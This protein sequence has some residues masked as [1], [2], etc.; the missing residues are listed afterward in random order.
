MK[1]PLKQPSMRH[2]FRSRQRHWTTYL[3]T[4]SVLN[5][6]RQNNNGTS[7]PQRRPREDQL[8]ATNL[9]AVI[10]TT[11]PGCPLGGFVTRSI[12][13]RVRG[14][15][16]CFVDICEL[17]LD[18]VLVSVFLW[19]RKHSLHRQALMYYERVVVSFRMPKKPFKIAF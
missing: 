18:K 14:T 11:R 3:K 1:L 4:L 15:R 13:V 19:S 2:S 9:V 7:A 12:R 10:L 17:D 5:T 16:D 8:L 6:N